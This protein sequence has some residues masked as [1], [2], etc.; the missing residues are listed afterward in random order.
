MT[1]ELRGISRMSKLEEIEKA[2]VELPPGEPAKFREWFDQFAGDLFDRKIERDRQRGKTRSV[3]RARAWR[4]AIF[5]K[6]SEALNRAWG[7]FDNRKR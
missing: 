5:D 6:K 2:I 3:G 1:G 4:P 7:R